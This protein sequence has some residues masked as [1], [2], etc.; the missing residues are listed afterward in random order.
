MR[1][2]KRCLILTGLDLYFR[3]VNRKERAA[4][5]LKVIKNAFSYLSCKV[6]YAFDI[7]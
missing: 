6:D 4:Y 1:R 2:L 5:M 3:K 7:K